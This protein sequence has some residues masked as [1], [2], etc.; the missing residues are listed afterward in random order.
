MF[1]EVKCQSDGARLRL[2]FCIEF[3]TFIFKPSTLLFFDPLPLSIQYKGI[4]LQGASPLKPRRICMCA[5]LESCCQS[6]ELAEL[7]INSIYIKT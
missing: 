3:V 6:R 1:Q 4:E 7:L 2:I 5:L